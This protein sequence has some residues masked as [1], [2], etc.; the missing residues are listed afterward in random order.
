MDKCVP[1]SKIRPK[2][3]ARKRSK[4]DARNQRSKHEHVYITSCLTSCT[5]EMARQE[6]MDTVLNTLGKISC[7]RNVLCHH[8][9]C[10]S[11]FS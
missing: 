1:P 10:W 8:K 7:G 11:L 6:E 4:R 2:R 5:S 9:E 3:R